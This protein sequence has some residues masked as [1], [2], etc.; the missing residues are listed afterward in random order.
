M[1]PSATVT[2]CEHV[3]ARALAGLGENHPDT[4]AAR[5][6][7]ATLYRR[8][9]RY[10]DASTQLEE[11]RNGLRATLGGEDEQTLEARQR[12]AFAYRLADR[13]TEAER[14]YQAVVEG[15]AR[16]LGATHPDTLVAEEH[17]AAVRRRRWHEIVG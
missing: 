12:L 8:A 10:D 14:E 7:L 1:D 13:L 9:R 16:T 5:S 15:R 17:L 11:L 6:T 4:L 3:L 2:D